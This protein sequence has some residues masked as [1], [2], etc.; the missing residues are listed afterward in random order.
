MKSY[1]LR[2]FAGGPRRYS[3]SE[4]DIKPVL[5]ILFEE[6]WDDLK[7]FIK[8]MY[9]NLDYHHPND[10]TLRTAHILEWVIYNT[11]QYKDSHTQEE[12]L[13]FMCRVIS[14][15]LGIIADN[16]EYPY[17]E[18][19]LRELLINYTHKLGEV[20]RRNKTEKAMAIEEEILGDT[21]PM[22]VYAI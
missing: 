10:K 1:L 9:D 12:L 15:N 20:R 13:Y 8:I 18:S 22:D 16:A 14:R 21:T 11:V 3:F 5:K 7:D 19:V 17:E 2:E 4:R 6:R